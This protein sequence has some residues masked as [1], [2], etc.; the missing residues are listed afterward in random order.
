[1]FALGTKLLACSLLAWAF[2]RVV[3]PIFWDTSLYGGHDW[4][5]ITAQR[6]ILLKSLSEFGQFPFWNPYAC[7]G[8]SAWGNVQGVV[9]LVS[10]L[11]PIYWL[12]ELREA[13][14][15]EVCVTLAASLVGSYV[16]AGRFASSPALKAMVAM[17]FSLNGRWA[18]Q[19]QSGH[20]WHLY[21]ALMPWVF[22]CFEL[23]CEPAQVAD[24]EVK[25]SGSAKSTL[26]AF[27]ARV[28]FGYFCVASLLIAQMVYAGA[29]Y[30]LPHTLL[31]LGVYASALTVLKRSYKPLSV[32]VASGLLGAAFSAPKL[33]PD[34]EMMS[35]FPRLVESPEYVDLGTLITAL[36][37]R[38]QSMTSRLMPMRDWGWHEYGMYVGLLPFAALLLLVPFAGR[39]DRQRAA[40]FTGIVGLLL[41]LGSFHRFAPW[42][43]LH[44]LPLFE[45][46]HVPSRW[47]YPA[48]LLFC[49]AAAGAAQNLL[50]RPTRWARQLEVLLLVIA[51]YIALDISGQSR[52]SMQG[53]F[54]RQMK[55]SLPQ[56]EQFYQLKR[57]VSQLCYAQADYAPEVLPAMMSGRGIIDCTLVAALNVWSK[58]RDDGR[59][60]GIGARGRDEADYR[61]EAFVMS[62]VGTVAIEHWSPNRVSLW[63]RG[64]KAG[65]RLILNQNYDP[66]WSA[67]GYEVE[68]VEDRAAV[69]LKSGQERVEFVYVSPRF[70]VGLIT[71][72]VAL[73]VFG[74]AWR[75]VRRTTPEQPQAGSK[76]ATSQS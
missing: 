15:L 74:V 31:L 40:R 7:G 24:A 50:E 71:C 22:W 73:V 43:L 35:R 57:P 29:I 59:V 68:N 18:M 55:P 44:R 16:Y 3:A 66:G 12:F 49:V 65:D 45:S 62:G 32:F 58:K 47:L 34:L 39:T 6:L 54:R 11:F 33:L 1:M 41:G 52:T 28:R 48:L 67:Q 5:E 69:R 4:D 63:V 27:A 51:A 26:L 13:L 17:V 72:V 8:H 61:G 42:S 56:K 19:A 76:P 10:P 36:T 20:A 53:A 23:A 70:W 64:G 21:Y 14:R 9:N 75:L 46:Q 37:A 38:G 2:V 25:S 60:I 30:P